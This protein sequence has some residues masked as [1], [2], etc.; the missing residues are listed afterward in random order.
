M[1]VMN[2]CMLLL[3]S[4]DTCFGGGLDLTSVAKK[5][6]NNQTKNQQQKTSAEWVGQCFSTAFWIDVCHGFGVDH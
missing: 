3:L 1:L 6:K 4:A 2:L 5:K